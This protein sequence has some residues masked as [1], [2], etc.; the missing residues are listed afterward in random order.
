MKNRLLNMLGVVAILGTLAAPLT[1]APVN[2][3]P[4]GTAS[5]DSEGFTSVVSDGNDGNRDP[6]FGN[7]SVWHTT[8]ANVTHF[9][10]VDLGSEFY[11]DRVQVFPR[12]TVP[13]WDDFSI[14][15]KDASDAVVFTQSYNPRVGNDIDNPWGTTD[16][17][18]VVGQTVTI[19]SNGTPLNTSHAEFEVYGQATQIGANIALN[20]VVTSSGA[21]FGSA[22][23]DANDGIIDGDFFN[24][25]NPGDTNG[26]PVYHSP[27]AAIGQFVQIDLGYNARIDYV[28]L[29]DRTD[30]SSGTVKVS[31]LDDTLA[32]VDSTTIDLAAADL[33]ANRYDAIFDP[34]G[35]TVGRYVKVETTG[36]T[37]L[38]LAEVEAIAAV[39]APM[40][41]LDLADI[42]GGG[43]GTGTG[44][45]AGVRLADG[46]L[47]ATH[48]GNITGGVAVNT[49]VAAAHTFIDSVFIPDGDIGGGAGTAIIPVSTTGVT[50]T[51]INDSNGASW[52]EIWNGHNT[53]VSS[54]LTP[55]SIL[56]AHA[57]K[58]ITFDLEAIA[59][60]N[61][62]LYAA[63]FS[64]DAMMGDRDGS[65]TYYVLVDGVVVDQVTLGTANTSAALSA[66][67]GTGAK[68]LTLMTLSDGLDGNDWSFIGDP[69]LTLKTIP[70]PAA[71]PAGL[72]MLIAV[73]ARRHRRTA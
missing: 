68:F 8:N 64:A 20:K 35:S 32:E 14:E 51:G 56:G 33:G 16:L 69:T 60:A 24:S 27:S 29:F 21:A 31:I 59:A 39:N 54:T 57:S 19:R 44:G 4:S 49:N 26:F 22:V 12:D 2:L 53:G 13:H 34:A 72:I 58:G 1:A 5:A 7:G 15:V 36:A 70:T 61:P 30:A 55:T 9:Y 73:G 23:G 46:T 66:T 50:T 40:S 48:R 67:M 17:R 71:L 47:T 25:S 3:A 63:L 37:F 38:Q 10:T 28:N 43:D 42:V 11:L 18:H 41:T 62:G 6:A 65:V 45:D 52:D